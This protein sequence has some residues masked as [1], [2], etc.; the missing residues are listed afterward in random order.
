MTEVSKLEY[1]VLKFQVVLCI[2]NNYDGLRI[3]DLW[4]N[5]TPTVRLVISSNLVRILDSQT[6][7]N[8]F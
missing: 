2:V 6:Y 5:A 4:E 8:R 3:V 1:L 7:K